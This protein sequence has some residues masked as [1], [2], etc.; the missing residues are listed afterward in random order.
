MDIRIIGLGGYSSI[1]EKIGGQSPGNFRR[2]IKDFGGLR[3]PFWIYV[4]LKVGGS[5]KRRL[6]KVF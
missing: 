3:W 6:F 1:V 4:L 2:R 5:G